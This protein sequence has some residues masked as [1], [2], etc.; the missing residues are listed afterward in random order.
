MRIE[1]RFRDRFWEARQIRLFSS[2]WFGGGDII[3]YSDHRRSGRHLVYRE[4]VGF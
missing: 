4:E 3:G 2:G 1:K